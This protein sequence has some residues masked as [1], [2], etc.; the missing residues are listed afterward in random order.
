M[1][2]RVKYVDY[3][4]QFANHEQEYMGIIRE[5]LSKGD[6]ILRHQLSAFEDNLARFCGTRFAVGV[7]NCTSALHLSLY[8]AGVGE[9][10]EVITVSHTFVATAAAVHQLGAQPVL[11]DISDDHNMDVGLVERAITCKTKAILPVHLNGRICSDIERLVE[12]ARDHNLVIIEDA[13]Q[14]LGASSGGKKAGSFGLAGCFSFYPAKLLGAFGDGGAIVTDNEELAGLL[15]LLRNHGRSPAGDIT[16]W[17]FN[18]RMDNLDAAVLDFKLARLPAW[19]ERRRE[20]AGMYNSLL[21]GVK[22]LKLPPPP[23]GA[24]R[25]DVF[26]NYE[27]EAQR[28]DDLVGHLNDRGIEVMLPWGG[29]GIHQFNT[30]GLAGNGGLIKTTAVFEKVIMLPIYPEL[31]N[32]HVEY[33]A[34][35]IREFYDAG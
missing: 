33:V 5:T 10:D 32:E 15:K 25:Y 31:E 22:E 19:I 17:G 12:I 26:Q 24:D 11:V 21:S 8:A 1:G 14:A 18:Y 4:K 28:R 29:K 2:W 30:L 35:A 13:A 7:S 20:I 3:P 9:G 27:I 34:S 23:Q 16:Q 6:L